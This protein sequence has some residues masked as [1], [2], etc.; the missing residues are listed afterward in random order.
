[1]ELEGKVNG[2]SVRLAI[3]VSQSMFL[4][5]FCKGKRCNGFDN[6]VE[7]KNKIV[8]SAYKEPTYKELIFHPQFYKETSSL[9][10]YVYKKFRLKETYFLGSDEVP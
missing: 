9:Y 2:K 6:N 8:K 10:L 7:I 4:F 3:H 5:F 1:M